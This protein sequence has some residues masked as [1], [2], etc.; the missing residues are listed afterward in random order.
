MKAKRFGK[1]NEEKKKEIKLT[2]HIKM[3]ERSNPF[4]FLFGKKS[5]E[6][7]FACWRLSTPNATL[8]CSCC[9]A[10]ESMADRTRIGNIRT[11]GEITPRNGR[12]L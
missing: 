4:N 12:I 5:I 2:V 3:I 8:A 11:V 6:F 10:D 7:T 9:I 1:S